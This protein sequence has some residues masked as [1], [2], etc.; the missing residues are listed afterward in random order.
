MARA[1]TK[2]ELLDFGEKEYKKLMDLVNGFSP[3]QQAGLEVFENRT[4]KDILAHLHDW[5]ELVFA[6]EREGK[7]GGKPIM[8]A[9]G[10]TWKDLPAF[11]EMLYRKSKDKSL[12][13]ILSD[14]ENSHKEAMKHISGY[15][16]DDL[17]TKAKFA[18]TGS[19]NIASYYASC[20]SSH[21]AWA[22]DLLK[23]LQKRV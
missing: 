12:S 9:E 10:Y 14:F 6:W 21:Y 4:I 19:T 11:N 7:S 20:T 18:W 22:S 2:Q 15:S 8:P 13:E 23:K 16:A 1:R 17:E 5:H 3:D